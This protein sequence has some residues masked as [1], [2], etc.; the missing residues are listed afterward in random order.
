[1]DVLIQANVKE[2]GKIRE[3]AFHEN[4]TEDK[5]RE[6]LPQYTQMA[7]NGIRDGS[8]GSS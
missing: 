4:P 6:Y 5:I 8:R 2:I 7:L 1:M 3:D